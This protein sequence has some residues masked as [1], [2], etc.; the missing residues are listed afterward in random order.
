MLGLL[1]LCAAYSVLRLDLNVEY[2]GA[3][4]EDLVQLRAPQPFGFR[5]L[6]PFAVGVLRSALGG[7]LEN[8]F[9]FSEFVATAALFAGLWRLS[10]KL[11]APATR[12]WATLG[13]FAFLPPLFLLRT[14]WPIFYPYDTPAMAFGVWGLS[15]VLAHNWRAFLGV[16]IF[17]TL[18]RETSELLLLAAGLISISHHRLRRD[19]PW[20]LAGLASYL[21]VRLAVINLVPAP[22]G[23]GLMQWWVDDKLRIV[24]NL[25]FL[26]SGANSLRVLGY[27]GGLPLLWAFFVPKMSTKARAWSLAALLHGIA[28]CF[29]G[30]VYEPRIFGEVS[31]FLYVAVVDSLQPAGFLKSSSKRRS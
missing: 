27:F 1:L 11:V 25:D 6:V 23:Q 29:V 14:V 10:G 7:S 21:A 26:T 16:T 8:W 18:N 30:N 12:G 20:L 2:R 4:W 13:F 28:L 19:W 5:V 22:P 24:N 31:L 3:R 17:A 15:Y 9:V